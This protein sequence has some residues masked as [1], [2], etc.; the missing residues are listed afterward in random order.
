MSNDKSFEEILE[1]LKKLVESLEMDEAS[2]EDSVKNFE[3]GMELIKK[4]ENILTQAQ[5][6]IE[7]IEQNQSNINL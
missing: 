5:H 7:V 2:L 3:T 6:K 4:A 1:N